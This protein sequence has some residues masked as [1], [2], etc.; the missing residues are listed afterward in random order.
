MMR[1]IRC[2][3]MIAIWCVGCSSTSS[4]VPSSTSPSSSTP[5]SSTPS[6]SVVGDSVPTAAFEDPTWLAVYGSEPAEP[7][8]PA[9]W[10]VMDVGPV[11]FAVPAGWAAPN[12]FTCLDPAVTGYVLLADL[13][14]TTSTCGSD[15]A[16]CPQGVCELPVSHMVIGSTRGAAPVTAPDAHVGMFDAWRLTDEPIETYRL[17]NGVE[18]GVA[19]PDAVQILATF[20]NSGW[21]RVLQDAPLADS[22]GW[23]RVDF[24]G[25]FALVPPAWDLIDLAHQD[26]PHG[27]F[28]DPG[29]CQDPWFWPGYPHALIDVADPNIGAGCIV[30]VEW[31]IHPGDGIWMRGIGHDA[32][33]GPD[34]ASGVIDGMS[35]SVLDRPLPSD[36]ATANPLVDVI[37]HTSTGAVRI[38]IGVGLDPSVARTIL[39]TLRQS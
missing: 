20:T 2:S 1:R 6:S 25:V 4:S 15:T 34:A 39:H 21:R 32:N 7:G 14:A 35:V 30:V 8:V 33:I 28:P 3:I 38:S 12:G 11:R 13:I 23:K 18:V 17:T 36:A 10:Q 29:T 24:G 22:A 26:I 9:G 19:G 31:P 37:V 5:S 27:F 16:A